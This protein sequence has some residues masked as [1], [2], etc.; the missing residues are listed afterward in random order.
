[1]G[2]RI[3]LRAPGKD[4][5]ETV[6]VGTGFSWGAFL[7]GFIWAFSKRMWFEGFAMLAVNLVLFGVALSGETA[8]LIGTVLSV[9]FGVACGVYGNQWHRRALEK[10]GYVVL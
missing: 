9:L 7:L 8:D 2:E 10:R 3:Y 6:G 4:E 5:T 1:M